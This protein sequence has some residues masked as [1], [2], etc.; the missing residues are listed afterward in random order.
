[1]VQLLD[2]TFIVEGEPTRI[3]RLAEDEDVI[4]V[5]A[6][7]PMGADL[8]FSVAATGS[9]QLLTSPRGRLD[10]TGVIVGVVDQGGL[11]FT[12][13]DFRD[14]NGNTRIAF[15]WDQGLTAQ[16][17]ER[18]PVGFNDGV[19]YEADD[20]NNALAVL[21]QGNDPFQVVRHQAHDASH[22]T[23]VAGIAAGN[24]R[25]QGV[26]FNAGQYIGTAPGA[27]IIYVETKK[28][29]PNDPL[30]SSDRVV[31]AITYIFRKAAELGKP[32]VVNVS[33]GHNG[34]SHEGES[35]VERTIDRLLEDPGRV[36]VKSAG[37]EADW[38]THA[39][40]RIPSRG[41]SRT[42]NW[43]VGGGL[44]GPPGRDSTPNEIEV[45]YSSRDRFEVRVHHPNGPQTT[46]VAP[47]NELNTALS[48]DVIKIRSERFHPL[49]GAARIFIHADRGRGNI[50][51]TS[52][53][54]QVELRGQEV[55]DGSF[56]AW[57]EVDVRDPQNNFADQSYFSE[58]CT[59]RE[60]SLSPPGTI[61]RGIAVG[62]YELNANPIRPNPSSSWGPTRDG[63]HKPDLVAPGTDITSTGARGNTPVSFGSTAQYPIRVTKT[64]T[65]VSAPHVAGICAQ[66]LQIDGQMTA[67]QIRAVLVATAK[68]PP[69]AGAAFD[70][71]WGYG[72]VDA[73]DAEALLR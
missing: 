48:S 4:Y 71:A 16:G 55:R 6:P 14:G 7:R 41:V 72:R 58:D 26:G 23:H 33:L 51:L 45:W 52:G 57:I 38:Q 70:D 35:I 63:R 5:E 62:N 15:L 24:G 47:G 43:I 59:V 66:L 20:I 25:S 22:A 32:C 1:V 44:K 29:Q 27:R 13:D 28:K 31:E 8:D 64:G 68:P 18:R 46:W 49:N 53:R 30:T 56:D 9:D 54:W 36:L 34:G 40:D 37:N 61:R 69:G 60:K 65:S 42:L 67:P 21:A 50:Y 19:Q 73:V 3:M 2:D 10:G 12:L 17:N 11:D 39:G